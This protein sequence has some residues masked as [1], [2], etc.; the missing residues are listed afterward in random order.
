VGFEDLFCGVGLA[1]EGIVQS[2][3][4]WLKIIGAADA[5]SFGI[6]K[7]EASTLAI[8]GSKHNRV[9]AQAWNACLLSTMGCPWKILI[10]ANMQAIELCL[11]KAVDL[12]SKFATLDRLNLFECVLSIQKVE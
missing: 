12:A 6:D 2:A 11:H 3:K 5:C 10:E 4:T 1:C 7:I 9:L 8:S